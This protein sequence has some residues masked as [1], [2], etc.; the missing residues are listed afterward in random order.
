MRLARWSHCAIPLLAVLSIGAADVRVSLVDAVKN[1]DKESLRTLV[2]DRATVKA[3]APDGTTALHWASYRDDVEAADLLLRAGADVNAATDLGVTPLWLA[4]VNA[5]AAMTQ[6][7]LQAGANPNIALSP[8]GETPL[9]EASRSGSVA[10]VEQLLAK[11]ANVNARGFRDQT[12]LMWAAAELHSDIVKVL[13]AHGGDVKAR[14]SVHEELMATEPHAPLENNRYVPQGGFTPLLF[15]IRAGD[16][17]SVKLL[18]GAGSDVN[19]KDS[20]GIAAIAH[21]THRGYREIVDFLLETGADPNVADAGF[22]PLHAA[23]MR[24]DEKMAASLLSHGADPNARVQTWTPMRRGSADFN[25]MPELVG[26]TPFWIAARVG[27]AN[28]MRLL[29]KHGADPKFVH[30]VDYWYEVP[31]D[32]GNAFRKESTNALMAAIGMAGWKARSWPVGPAQ[33]PEEGQTRMVEAAKAALD[34]GV[35]INATALDNQTALDFARARKNQE[36]VDLL[37]ARG[38]QSGKDAATASPGNR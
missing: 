2:K 16:F 19:E 7:L 25:F 32:Q 8:S 12:A 31:G 35:D 27:D 10:V 36:L 22:Y 15:A 33:S 23:L 4:S 38:A 13:L 21:A 30:Q 1:G 18:V 20:W 26:A 37:V 6:R 11:G 28:L 3:A 24:R 29:V 5:S 17:S 14:T 9:M 34:L